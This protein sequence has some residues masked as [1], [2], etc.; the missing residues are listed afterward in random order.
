MRGQH[1]ELMTNQKA[2]N[3]R[4]FSGRKICTAI[5]VLAPITSL[6]SGNGDIWFPSVSS[7]D[8]THYFFYVAKCL[9]NQSSS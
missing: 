9:N 8:L 5:C 3:K 6:R 4:E 2:G 7:Y 1:G